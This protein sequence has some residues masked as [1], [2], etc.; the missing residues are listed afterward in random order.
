MRREEREAAYVEFVAA[1]Q[2]HLRRIAHGVCR[3]ASRAEDV[4]QDA[5]VKLYVAW[6]RVRLENAEAYTRRII[7]RA[8]LDQ[9]RRPFRSREVSGLDGHDRGEESEAS[10]EDRSVLHD[11]LRDLPEM[12]R[13]VV[14]LRHW[15]GLSVR[16]TAQDLGISEGT[17]KSYCSRGLEKLQAALETS[18][19]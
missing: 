5:L 15:V 13:K 11:A 7:V 12:Q 3:D 8:N 16:E 14:V 19:S 17:V 4:L 18:R 10:Y 2:S 1:R 9:V 6:P